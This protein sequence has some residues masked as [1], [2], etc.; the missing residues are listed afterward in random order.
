M[1]TTSSSWPG[2][3]TTCSSP[4][5]QICPGRTATTPGTRP[6]A[7]RTLCAR[8]RPCGA[9]STPATSPPLSPSSGSKAGLPQE[10]GRAWV[11][12]EKT[13]HCFVF[14]PA[15]W[16]RGEGEYRFGDK[17]MPLVSDRPG[18]ESQSCHFTGCLMFSK[19]LSL[20]EPQFL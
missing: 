5:S 11:G 18:I 4:S 20:S 2:P 9:L 15:M 14:S 16:D 6:I 7:W 17:S 3:H 13:A 10:G 12:A 19:Y 1:C 8:T